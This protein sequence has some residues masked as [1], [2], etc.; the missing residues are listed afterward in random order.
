MTNKK[1][2]RKAKM[3][4]TIISITLILIAFLSV[5]NAKPI[6]EYY[7][8]ENSKCEIIRKDGSKT[9]C[10]QKKSFYINI[11]D[12][13]K[14]DKK[15]YLRLLS[16]N[17]KIIE[18]KDKNFYIY[19][20]SLKG[21][22]GIFAKL[23]Q[24]DIIA[25]II[26]G[27]K[28]KRQAAATRSCSIY[29]LYPMVSFVTGD[30]NLDFKM[31]KD[32]VASENVFIAIFN[33]NKKDQPIHKLTLKEDGKYFHITFMPTQVGLKHS[34]AYLWKLKDDELIYKEGLIIISDIDNNDL[35]AKINALLKEVNYKVNP[36][37]KKALICAKLG[38]AWK[39]K[40]ILEKYKN[41]NLNRD[42]LQE[43]TQYIT[44]SSPSP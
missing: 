32:Q 11:G 7:G 15:I 22:K 10:N 41:T 28:K 36:E 30:D 27:Y 31:D 5:A 3:K 38:Y 18:K 21:K 44:I 13:L 17:I 29:D 14:T 42:Y 19:K 6:A 25:T 1:G 2:Q 39:A 43:L 37:L 12:I 20:P 24:D 26:E 9:Q 33:V 8:E 4:N 16:D 34:T 35:D 40:N 23:F